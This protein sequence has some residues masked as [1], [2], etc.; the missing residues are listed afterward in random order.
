LRREE[1]DPFL[2]QIG[3]VEQLIS[4]SGWKLK[5]F[6]QLIWEC[7]LRGVEANELL[8]EDLDTLNRTVRIR[9][10]K[11]G[12]PRTLRISEKCLQMLRRLP[13]TSAKIFGN[14]H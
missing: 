6:L 12:K 2:P 7:A 13:R 10:R 4:G 5:S 1:T 8:W 3:E 11:R 14:S 9:P